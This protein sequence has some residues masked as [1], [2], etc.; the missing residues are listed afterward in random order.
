MMP[1]PMPRT[2][3]YSHRPCWLSADN[4]TPCFVTSK[5]LSVKNSKAQYCVTQTLRGSFTTQFTHILRRKIASLKIR[6]TTSR[7]EP[8][9]KSP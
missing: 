4:V 2:R 7:P 9:A 6:S 5:S 3:K 8:A 1:E